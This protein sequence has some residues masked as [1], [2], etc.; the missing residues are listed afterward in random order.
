M[1]RIQLTPYHCVWLLQ[2]IV[3]E[4]LTVGICWWPLAANPSQHVCALEAHCCAMEPIELFLQLFVSPSLSPP[5]PG[6]FLTNSKT[7]TT[8]QWEQPKE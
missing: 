1:T 7:R 6:L 4:Q 5:S 3:R 8:A 2:H